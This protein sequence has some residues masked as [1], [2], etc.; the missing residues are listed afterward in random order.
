MPPN[1]RTPV[2]NRKST[3]FARCRSAKTVASSSTGG[4]PAGS[5]ETMNV[6]AFERARTC[7]WTFG[8][9]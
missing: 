1:S 9:P 2:P 8:A 5:S 6:L 3:P 4:S 7:V